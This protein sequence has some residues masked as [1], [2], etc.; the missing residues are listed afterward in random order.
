LRLRNDS[1]SFHPVHPLIRAFG[2]RDLHHVKGRGL[3]TSPLQNDSTYEITNISGTFDNQVVTYLPPYSAPGGYGNNLFEYQ[4]ASTN[5]LLDSNGV[6]FS[7]ADGRIINLW[8]QSN[9]NPTPSGFASA[10]ALDIYTP[11]SDP[12]IPYIGSYNNPLA[13]A[14]ASTGPLSAPAAAPAPLPILGLPAV[15]FYSRKLKKRIKA[16][17]ELSSS[18]LV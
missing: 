7:L 15:L 10:N 11:T 12:L 2:S 5:W 3:E 4:S 16:S 6:V 8:Y 14:Q 9:G 18:S 1:P 13:S 17:R